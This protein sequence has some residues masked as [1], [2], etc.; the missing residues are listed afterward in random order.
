MQKK[1]SSKKQFS[2]IISEDMNVYQSEKIETVKTL[3]ANYDYISQ[4]EKTNLEGKFT[5]PKNASQAQYIQKL[6]NSNKKIVV[7]T[8]VAGTGKTL[9]ATEIAVKFLLSNKTERI[10]FTRPN[11]CVDEDLGYLPGTLE[12]KLAPYVRPIYDILY[13]F[14]TPDEVTKMLQDK[15]FEIAPLGFMR[16]RTFK[17]TW[18]I[19]DEMQNATISQMKMLLTRIGEGSRMVITGDLDQCDL[20]RD[21]S[22]LTDFLQKLQRCRSE[23]ISSIEFDTG[24]IQREPVVKEVLEIYSSSLPTSYLGELIVEKEGTAD[25]EKSNDDDR[26]SPLSKDLSMSSDDI[27]TGTLSSSSDDMFSFFP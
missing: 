18:I 14:F 9:F 21:A 11:V 7:A 23:S 8:G 12:D 20:R 3:F 10:I 2:K 24:D 4:K 16:G 17:N 27:E 6:N 15:I 25:S 5:K 1:R 22:G 26:C 13:R 19:A